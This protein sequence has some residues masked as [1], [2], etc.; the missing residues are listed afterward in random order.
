MKTIGFYDSGIGGI[1][2]LREAM[3]QLPN[4][5]YVYFGD[6]KNAPY[7]TKQQN[8]IEAFALEAVNF[9]LEKNVKA[10]VIACNTATAA[11]AAML[12]SRFDLPIIGMEPALKPAHELRGNGTILVMA[13]P[14][15]LELPKFKNLMANYGEGAIPVPCPGLMEF[16]EQGI[17][18]GDA[19]DKHITSLLA[20]YLDKPI[21]AV[22]LGCTHYIFAKSAIAKTL[23]PATQILD[24]N[25]G[26]VR[27]LERRLAEM[28]ALNTDDS[29]GTVNFYVSDESAKT[30]ALMDKLLFKNEKKQNICI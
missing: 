17:L 16:V 15:T 21:D 27:Q 28:N 4:E 23:P 5:N 24:G 11:A 12:R 3:K 18:E 13:T 2:V 7:G 9:L 14:L 22:V 8:E 10:I 25:L 1:S 30:Y 29:K 26:T 19:L 20:P 6:T